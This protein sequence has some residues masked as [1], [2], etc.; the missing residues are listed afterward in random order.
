MDLAS[1]IIQS[2]I[3]ALLICLLLGAI[4]LSGKFS[5]VAANLCLIGVFFVGTTQIARS[6]HSQGR[7]FVGG[8]F[9]LAG[10]CL[11]MSQWIKP[12][13]QNGVTNGGGSNVPPPPSSAP[14]AHDAVK[15]PDKPKVAH[16][17]ALPE[18]PK[19]EITDI[20][21]RLLLNRAAT[22]AFELNKSYQEFDMQDAAISGEAVFA[23]GKKRTEAAAKEN[24]ENRK[25]L[26]TT[27]WAKNAD[28]LTEGKAVRNEGER[29]G[30][31][32]EQEMA[33]LSDA[34]A[35]F[36]DVDYFMNRIH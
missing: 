19:A 17:A 4:A 33:D 36:G 15:A 8:I 32:K 35:K 23:G 1:D 29:R 10:F 3:T 24:Q 27:V 25:I 31:N 28:K 26:R 30:I 16:P 11:I 34:I 14:V 22:I 21:N 9:M 7:L 18:P 2:P 12:S 6:T 5:Q 13:Q 20:S